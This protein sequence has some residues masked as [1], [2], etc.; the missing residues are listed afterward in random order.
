MRV[1]RCEACVAQIR[2]TREILSGFCNCEE[3]SVTQYAASYGSLKVLSPLII[4]Y[5]DRLKRVLRLKISKYMQCAV[6]TSKV[7]RSFDALVLKDDWDNERLHTARTTIENIQELWG[8]KQVP[9]PAYSPDLG[10]SDYHLFRSMAHF[11]PGENVKNLKPVEVVIIEFF[12][13]KPRNRDTNRYFKYRYYPFDI[14]QVSILNMGFSIDTK[15]RFKMLYRNVPAHDKRRSSIRQVITTRELQNRI[16][17][18]FSFDRSESIPQAYYYMIVSRDQNIV[19]NGNIKIGNLSF[20]EVEKFKY[21]GATVTNINDTR[22]E[23]KHRINIDEYR[24]SPYST[25]LNRI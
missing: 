15:Y 14:M 2:T 3:C 5:T 17:N 23:I 12:A 4:P 21:L 18:R 20:E 19:R 6:Y 13:S 9:H 22:D 1:A 8:I 11:M 16:Y 7:N 25:N 10:P 24:I